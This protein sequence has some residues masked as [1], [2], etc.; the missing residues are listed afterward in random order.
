LMMSLW[1]ALRMNMMISYQE[2]VRTFLRFIYLCIKQEIL[3]VAS[4][5]RVV[6]S[7]RAEFILESAYNNAL[8][9]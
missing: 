1:D 5:N 6:P 2:L 3:R 9:D 4:N 7:V 8:C